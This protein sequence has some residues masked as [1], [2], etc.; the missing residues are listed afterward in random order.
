MV[1]DSSHHGV[2]NA[3]IFFQLLAVAVGHGRL[4]SAHSFYKPPTQQ[5]NVTLINCCNLQ[6]KPVPRAH[7]STG[8]INAPTFQCA[9][10]VFQQSETSMRCHDATEAGPI[11]EVSAVYIHIQ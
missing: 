4:V 3:V 5:A 7:S 6:T 2:L 1:A 9:G 10:P 11:T 8:G